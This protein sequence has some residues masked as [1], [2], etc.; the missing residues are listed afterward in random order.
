MSGRLTN[1][2]KAMKT[3]TDSTGGE[4]RSGESWRIKDDQSLGGDCASPGVV[5]V[6]GAGTGNTEACITALCGS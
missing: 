1:P 4:L 2:W 3:K 6:L 5:E